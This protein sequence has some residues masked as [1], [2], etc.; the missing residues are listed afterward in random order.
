MVKKK[1]NWLGNYCLL[2]SFISTTSNYVAF[3]PEN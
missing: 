1:S 3:P 2:C